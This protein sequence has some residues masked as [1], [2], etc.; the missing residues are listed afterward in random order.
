MHEK[1]NEAENNF[2]NWPD[3]LC[4]VAMVLNQPLSIDSAQFLPME[5]P[6]TLAQ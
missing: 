2:F 6:Q 3:I 1:M 5:K 4:L